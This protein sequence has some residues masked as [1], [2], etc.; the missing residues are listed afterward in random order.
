MQ[1]ISTVTGSC[2][3][4]HGCPRRQC[5]PFTSYLFSLWMW[6]QR[7]KEKKCDKLVSGQT[8]KFFNLYSTYKQI[9]EMKKCWRNFFIFVLFSDQP[10]ISYT[11]KE[12]NYWPL[13]NLQPD[14]MAAH[15]YLNPNSTTAMRP[16]FIQSFLS[17]GWFTFLSVQL[18]S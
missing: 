10:V 16:L 8:A 18:T 3:D 4:A 1:W 15:F 2:T 9:W 17:K 14:P 6:F 11:H 12:R 7:V 13:L 5:P